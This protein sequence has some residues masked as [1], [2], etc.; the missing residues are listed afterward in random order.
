MRTGLIALAVSFLLVL[1]GCEND[2]GAPVPG[3]CEGFTLPLGTAEPVRGDLIALPGTR[4]AAAMGFPQS[5]SVTIF[6]LADRKSHGTVAVPGASSLTRLVRPTGAGRLFVLFTTSAIPR[7]GVAEIDAQQRATLQVRDYPGVMTRDAVRGAAFDPIRRM[8]YLS[9]YGAEPDLSGIVAVNAQ[10]LE[11]LDLDADGAV[12]RVALSN[13]H[14]TGSFQFPGDVAF[15]REGDQLVV[16]NGGSRALTFVPGPALAAAHGGD[17]QPA[18]PRL[19][20]L[21]QPV[22]VDVDPGMRTAVVSV[23]SLTLPAV[24]RLVAVDLDTRA[25]AFAS[26]ITIWGEPSASEIAVVPGTGWAILSTGVGT[27][28]GV[29][30]FDWRTGD[31]VR[32]GTGLSRRSWIDVA[33]A[34]GLGV[35]I[36]RASGSFVG[37]C[38]E[39]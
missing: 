22:A 7:P 11:I 19:D 26:D 2:A 34:Y 5:S 13:A 10:T 3:F 6:D 23:A 28:A 4:F 15:D 8:I 24:H 39:R 27:E 14:Y 31:V 29:R 37:F 9:T 20:L 36:D 32:D 25:I 1:S 33:P 21:G 17:P 18:L 30:V 38:L 12:D 35:G 16:T